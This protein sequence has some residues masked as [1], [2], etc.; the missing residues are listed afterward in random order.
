MQAA[1]TH[2]QLPSTA[3]VPVETSQVR[4]L[5]T[6]ARAACPSWASANML[7]AKAHHVRCWQQTAP[8]C[9]VSCATHG[10]NRNAPHM[11]PPGPPSASAAQPGQ[12]LSLPVQVLLHGKGPTLI[13]SLKTAPHLS[14]PCSHPFSPGRLPFALSCYNSA[15]AAGAHENTQEATMCT[16]ITDEAHVMLH[17]CHALRIPVLTPTPDGVDTSNQSRQQQP[18]SFVVGVSYLAPQ[19]KTVTFVGQASGMIEAC[20]CARHE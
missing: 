2:Q 11:R 12:S 15:S 1:W 5:D 18:C 4:M 20:S 17:P 19:R 10:C 6:C 3:A 16:I 8:M 7:V 14:L 9:H 13:A